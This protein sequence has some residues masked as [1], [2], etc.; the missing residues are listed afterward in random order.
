VARCGYSEAHQHCTGGN[1]EEEEDDLPDRFVV[2]LV[3][4]RVWGLGFRV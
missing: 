3:G 4:L 2:A 1:P